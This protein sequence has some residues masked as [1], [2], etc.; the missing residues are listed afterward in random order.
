[1]PMFALR[2]NVRSKSRPSSSSWNTIPPIWFSELCFAARSKFLYYQHCNLR[3]IETVLYVCFAICVRKGQISFDT[4]EETLCLI[5]KCI[6]TASSSNSS[7]RPWHWKENHRNAPQHSEGGAQC[8][9]KLK[10]TLN[11]YLMRQ[12]QELLQ[13]LQSRHLEASMQFAHIGTKLFSKINVKLEIF[14]AKSNTDIMWTEW[15]IFFAEN[16]LC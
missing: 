13:V 7:S 4:K 9:Q 11:P 10:T 15:S 5:Y 6:S 8:A 1:M 3:F 12:P 14:V 2:A 16:F